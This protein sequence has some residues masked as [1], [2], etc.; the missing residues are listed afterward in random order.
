MPQVRPT[1]TGHQEDEL[2]RDR[3]L[4]ELVEKRRCLQGQIDAIPKIERISPTPGSNL[5]AKEIIRQL[6]FVKSE[7]SHLGGVDR[8]VDSSPILSS[9]LY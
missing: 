6:H 8:V 4:E 9:F 2:D 1:I 5:L 3:L 7:I